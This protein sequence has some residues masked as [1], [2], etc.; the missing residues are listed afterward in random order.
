[1][2][3]KTKKIVIAS[4]IIGAIVIVSTALI[5]RNKRKKLE[6]KILGGSTDV[7][8]PAKTTT[9]SVIFP[10]KRGSG[11]NTAEKNAVKV[12]QRY[13][14][15]KGILNPWLLITILKEDG[16]FG[17]LTEAALLKLAG[18]KEVSYSLYKDM[19][20]Y[21]STQSVLTTTT[22]TDPNVQKNNLTLF[23][24]LKLFGINI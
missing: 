1:M 16:I 13:I 19:E 6:A 17:P 20:A 7:V 11:T 22:S 5:I 10:L 3:A 12:I 9:T 4:S 14:N 21:I 23:N 15:A 8:E 24:P 2:Q 18:I